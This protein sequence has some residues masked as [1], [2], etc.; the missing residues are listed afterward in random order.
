MKTIN[1]LTADEL[2]GLIADLQHG[3]RYN[4]IKVKYNIPKMV[5]TPSTI[6]ECEKLIAEKDPAPTS[7]EKKFTGYH[8]IQHTTQ[9]QHEQL[10]TLGVNV[11]E[12]GHYIW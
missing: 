10:M 9:Q 4:D 11:N 2:R 3:V 5:F 12:Q 8:S 7:T 6:S 1:D